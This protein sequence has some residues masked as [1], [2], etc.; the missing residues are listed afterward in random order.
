MR[1]IFL[2]AVLLS[3]ILGAFNISSFASGAVA[4][5]SQAPPT[6]CRDEDGNLKDGDLDVLAIFDDSK[7]LSGS[8]KRRGS[9]VDG[10]RFDAVEEFLTSFAGTSSNRRKNFGLIKFGATSKEIVPLEEITK[11]NFESKIKIIRAKIPNDPLSQEK[12]TNY[13]VALKSATRILKNRD[14]SNCKILIWFTD[15]VFDRSDSTKAGVDGEDARALEREVCRTGG[16]AAQIQNQDINTFVIFLKGSNESEFR[17]R[18]SISQDAMQVITGDSEPNFAS[19]SSGREIES[20]GC[21][22]DDKRHLGEVLSANDANELT[23]YLVDLV[24]IADR[25]ISVV[26]GDCPIQIDQADSVRLPSGHLIEWVSVTTWNKTPTFSFESLEISSGGKKMQFNEVFQV[27]ASTDASER[28]VRFLIKEDMRNQLTSGWSLS[29]DGARQTCIRAKI[30]DLEFR[31]KK[32]EPQFTPLSPKGLPKQLFD[33]RIELFD[34]AGEKVSV[35]RALTLSQVS[36]LLQVDFGELFGEKDSGGKVNVR[37]QIDGSFEVQPNCSLSINIIDNEQFAGKK[38][39]SSR[40]CRVVPSSGMVTK[41]DGTEALKNLAKNCSKFDGGWQLL[42]DGLPIEQKGFFPDGS[43]E[44]TLS[45]ESIEAAPNNKI[46]CRSSGL[47]ILISSGSAS[48]EINVEV[49]LKLLSPAPPLWRLIALLLVLLFTLLSLVVLK[50]MNMLIIKA[51]RKDDFYSYVT[52][53]ELLPGE[54]DRAIIKWPNSAR[55]FEIDANKLQ[56]TRGDDGRQNLSVGIYKFELRLPRL[57]HPFEYARLQLVD[58]RPSVFWR[59][60]SQRDGLTLSFTSAICLVATS[61]NIPTAE[62]L[63]E[64]DVVVLVPKRGSDAGLEGVTKIVRSNVGDLAP[65]LLAKIRQRETE[66]LAVDVEKTFSLSDLKKS[67]RIG[68]SKDSADSVAVARSSSPNS[69]IGGP[70]KV[71]QGAP[72]DRPQGVPSRVQSPPQSPPLQPPNRPR[73]PEPPQR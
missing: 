22:L 65:Q 42:K 61:P 37:I 49:R 71:P 35:E 29:S 7:S 56:P 59:T 27:N 47:P 17:K 73:P 9:D 72:P 57:L 38:I 53:A 48:K 20:S 62:R 70:A 63:T 30:R 18:R 3:L 46:E 54:F 31:M 58:V 19:K 69:P 12:K 1:K 2:T 55:D 60:N 28:S 45:L 44:L 10:K 11:D 6:V 66:K 33:G 51:P 68:K 5:A 34:T 43:D 41:Y 8:G 13:I 25:G 14:A 15:G 26:E 39:S 50:F 52:S 16:L 32:T 24:L 40:G 36:G 67:F 21:S 64:V 4:A 23:G